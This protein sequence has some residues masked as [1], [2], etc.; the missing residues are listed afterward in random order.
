M[1]TALGVALGYPFGQQDGIA[2]V[3]GLGVDNLLLED[4]SNLLLEDGS[5][6]LLE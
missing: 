3:P 2:A 6:L 4:G 5:L 1:G